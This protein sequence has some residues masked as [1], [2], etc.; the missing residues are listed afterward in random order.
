MGDAGARRST[1]VSRLPIFRRSTSKRRD[2]LPSS[3][4]SV[5]NGV[6]TS[7]PSSTNSSSSSVGK[8][9]SIF[10][11]PSIAFH[12]KKTQEHRVEAR[13]SNL[14][15]PN[16]VQC[17]DGSSR[18]EN[19][20]E[21]S[22]TK[23]RHSFGLSVTRSKRITRS[24]TEDFDKG[25]DPSHNK[26]V[27]MNCISSG[28]SSIDEGDDSGF[29]D[30]HS[31]HS[32]KHSSRKLL[33]K[34]FST[35]YKLSKNVARSPSVTPAD[36]PKVSPE[37]NLDTLR[38][39]VIE[40][41]S[42]YLQVE[43]TEGSLHSP[44]LSSDNTTILTPS[45][46]VP[47]SADSVS[48]ADKE[49]LVS[50]DPNHDISLF[51]TAVVPTC[52]DSPSLSAQV[53]SYAECSFHEE[54]AQLSSL[55]VLEIQSRYSQ[56]MPETEGSPRMV[57]GLESKET[58]DVDTPKQV[59]NP[60]AEEIASVSHDMFSTDN[61]L[62][63]M[64]PSTGKTCIL[65]ST[66]SVPMM[67]QE[68]CHGTS[69][70]TV[71]MNRNF[72]P[73]HEEKWVERRLR[74]SSE[75]TSGSRRLHG[76]RDSRPE[77]LPGLKKQ[78]AGSSSSKMNSMDVLNKLGSC[79]LD[80][81][82]LM[83]DLEFLED[84]RHQCENVAAKRFVCREDSN[85]SIKS[86]L[87]I[88]HVPA[89]LKVKLEGPKLPENPNESVFTKEGEH[90]ELR[91]AR[92][93]QW[94]G[95]TSSDCSFL[96]EE[97][98]V[99]GLDPLSLRLMMQDCTAVKTMLLKLKRILQESTEMSPASSTHSLPV[100]PI[101]EM[102]FPLKDTKDESSLLRLQLKEKDEL[103]SQLRE[104][105]DSCRSLQKERSSQADKSTQTEVLSHDG[106]VYRSTPVSSRRQTCF[107]SK[108]NCEPNFQHKGQ[109]ISTYTHRGPM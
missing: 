19:A 69:H 4:S 43:N 7:S 33:P 86:C 64:D 36:Q 45:E 78:R 58:C 72:S 81:D 21:N 26:N 17:L 80:E 41:S 39:P 9:R 76:V 74:S 71:T 67:K 62:E 31:K 108:S 10:R 82:D 35:H 91:P 13:D 98:S 53:V 54:T 25:K 50:A 44:L 32:V 68:K 22:K 47:M 1:L 40:E 46:F 95:G 3:P 24:M 57:G 52:V 18:K 96:R 102:P 37:A 12:S 93:N 101:T 84:Q 34:S 6:H 109:K 97:E 85:H 87:E 65:A 8:R 61:G 5:T 88:L 15:L 90:G 14:N 103:I 28:R 48:E 23:M 27:F 59:N 49:I 89:E 51:D 79:D 105:L 99:G 66:N 94:P 30:D 75:G 42:K 70:S 38:R 100:S 106:T 20:D 107:T 55:E 63:L 73:R 11:T 77:D 2:S 92:N 83:L 16:G 104:E 29:P 56:G 60:I